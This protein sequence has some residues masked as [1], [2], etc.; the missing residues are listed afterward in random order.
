MYQSC[1]RGDRVRSAIS[2]PSRRSSFFSVGFS[3]Q[4]FLLVRFSAT[5]SGLQ[6]RDS[7]GLSF[8]GSFFNS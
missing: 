2:V 3:L 5:A 6:L 4:S 8:C 7:T 1:H